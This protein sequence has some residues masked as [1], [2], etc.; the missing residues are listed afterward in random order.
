MNDPKVTSHDKKLQEINILKLRK[1]LAG[2]PLSY[3]PEH[4]PFCI[5][6]ICIQAYFK[7]VID[8]HPLWSFLL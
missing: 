4:N 2:I 1:E 5:K 7:S 8:V 3:I 6:C